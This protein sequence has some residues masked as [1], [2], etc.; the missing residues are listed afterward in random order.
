MADTKDAWDEVGNTASS[1]GAKLRAH[2]HDARGEP[3]A[4][5]SEEVKAAFQTLAD[6]LDGA[7]DAVGQAA[8][9]D[10][11]RADL[12][13]MGNALADALGST[14]EDVGEEVRR[15]FRSRP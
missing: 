3:S 10:A 14:F 9:D 4:E 8:K 7:M 12:R 13:Q 5:A 15:I 6:A 1:L 11:V 2:Y